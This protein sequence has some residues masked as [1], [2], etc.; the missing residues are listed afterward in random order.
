M[1]NLKKSL[2]EWMEQYARSPTGIED[3]E[4]AAEVAANTR[5]IL[6]WWQQ[7]YKPWRG[8]DAK[9]NANEVALEAILR[10]FTVG[11]I[12]LSDEEWMKRYGR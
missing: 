10:V 5:R 2:E 12:D 6:S 8:H 4:W 3:E 7:E 11:T 9:K 1:S